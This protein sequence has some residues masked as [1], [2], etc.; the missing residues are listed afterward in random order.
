MWLQNLLIIFVVVIFSFA[1]YRALI[2]PFYRTNTVKCFPRDHKFESRLDMR[3]IRE[4]SPNRCI[5][6]MRSA[7]SQPS[8][9][10]QVYDQLSILSISTNSLAAEVYCFNQP[11][12][13]SEIS[14]TFTPP[15][16]LFAS[17][18]GSGDCIY[19]EISLAD[20]NSL[21]DLQSH[22]KFSCCDRT[23]CNDHGLYVPLVVDEK[24]VG[25]LRLLIRVNES[26][27]PLDNK[28]FSLSV[29]TAKVISETLR[30][31]YSRSVDNGKASGDNSVAEYQ[32]SLSALQALRTFAKLL[33]RR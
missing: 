5:L 32:Q 7:Y 12:M 2:S 31:S 9:Y 11:L 27:I 21:I 13:R 30:P 23:L 15:L 20:I 29:L 6:V 1:Q 8:L 3:R 10:H 22:Q 28:V 25:V 14:Q 26:S 24:M 17:C 33:R 18:F 16:H 19:S 4:H